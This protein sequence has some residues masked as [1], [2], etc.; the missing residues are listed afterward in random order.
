M[1]APPPPPERSMFATRAKKVKMATKSCPECDQQQ[2]ECGAA[3]QAD[4]FGP[5]VPSCPE[6]NARC[7]DSESGLLAPKSAF[8]Q[9]GLLCSRFRCV[10]WTPKTVPPRPGRM[11]KCDRKARSVMMF[12][13]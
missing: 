10:R 13:S 2:Q 4:E 5:S 11:L 7:A 12:S 9:A 1:P 8:C 6:E 3:A